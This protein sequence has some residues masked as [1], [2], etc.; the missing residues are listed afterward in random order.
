MLVGLTLIKATTTTKIYSRVRQQA[1]RWPKLARV[2]NIF[3]YSLFLLQQK[4]F[5]GLI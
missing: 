2:F 4:S 3:L 5:H 1:A